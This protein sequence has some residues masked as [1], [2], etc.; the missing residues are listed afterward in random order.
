[1]STEPAAGRLYIV[2]FTGLGSACL[3]VPVLRGME[4]A[5]PR[6]RYTYLENALLRDPELLDAAGLRGLVGLAPSRWRRFDRSDWTDIAEF[7]ERH[8]L[9]TV[10]NFRN[11]D[12]AVDGRYAEFRDWCGRSGLRLRWHDL[13][14]VDDVGPL[15]VRERMARVLA[16]AGLTVAPAPDEW[17][18]G[19]APPPRGHRDQRLVGLFSSASST[20][21][22]W[23]TDRWL[24]L[25]RELAA[26][27]VTF[28]VLS[29]SG[30]DELDL[31]L[32]LAERLAAVVP[33]HRLVLAP[34][35]GVRE[36]VA[37]LSTLSVLV[38]NDTGV[39]H[40]AAACGTPVVSVFLSTDARVWRPRSRT[41]VAVQSAV[42]ARCPNQRPLQGNCTRHYDT[43]DAPCHLD[44]PPEVIAKA[45]RNVLP[46]Q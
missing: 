3:A 11:P 27:D 35:G 5:N 30:G 38:A 45:V 46:A 37:R 7:I 41:A 17:L 20:A 21:K 44:L 26:D 24:G 10:V 22:R 8:R 43:C 29:G 34:A 42:G 19:P 32:D 6:V 4:E 40:V 39:G 33:R 9:D 1:M 14:E 2:D 13:Y 25:A 23:P 31:T 18:R 36:L 16:A 28:V 12:L 15:H